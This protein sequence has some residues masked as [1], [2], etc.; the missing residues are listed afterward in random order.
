MEECIDEKGWQFDLCPNIIFAN[1]LFANYHMQRIGYYLFLLIV[2]IFAIIPFRLI[3]IFSDFLGIMFYHVIGYRKKMILNNLKN[4]FPEKSEAEIRKICK[5]FYRNLSDILLEAIKGFSI[6]E[7]S[8]SKR[9]K[10]N[11]DQKLHDFFES[12]QSV[13]GATAHLANWEW[14][15]Y[16]SGINLEH[17]VVGVYK[18]VKQPYINQHLIRS[19]SKFNVLLTEMKETTKYLE[20]LKPE[21][22]ILVMLIADQRPSDPEKA[23]W[24]N[25]LNR[26]TAFFYGPEKFS[27][28]YDLPVLFFAIHR[29]KRGYYEVVARWIHDSATKAEKGEIIKKYAKTLEEEIL[30]RPSEWLWSHSRW[31][32]GRPEGVS[33]N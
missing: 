32:H 24:L 14:G 19:R 33:L 31:K 5:D 22:P 13:I 20:E 30:E 11:F 27:I 26:E 29:I 2:G 9:Y 25:F 3:Y 8:I 18:K 1:L 17:Q 28:Q 21:K 16:S 7:K 15:A 23:Y 12:G 4:T 10:F 6:S